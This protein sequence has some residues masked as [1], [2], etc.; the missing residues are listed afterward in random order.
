MTGYWRGRGHK[1]KGKAKA[2]FLS[3]AR[4]KLR[5]KVRNLR[6]RRKTFVRYKCEECRSLKV[7]EVRSDTKHTFRCDAC[8]HESRTAIA[9]VCE[10][11]GKTTFRPLQ[12]QLANGAFQADSRGDN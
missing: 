2:T 3:T 8:R 5:V 4:K 1:P 10:P 7:V 6:Q 11:Q 12:P 9:V